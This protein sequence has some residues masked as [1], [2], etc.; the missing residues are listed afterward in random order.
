M[1]FQRMHQAVWPEFLHHTMGIP[2]EQ[3]NTSF[4]DFQFSLCDSDGCAVAIGQTIPLDWKGVP[5]NLPGNFVEIFKRAEECLR[6]NCF[7]NTLS[8][9]AAVVGPDHQR[10]GLSYAVLREMAR[11]AVRFGYNHL[12]APVRP[13]Q[14]SSFPHIPLDQY[15]EWKRADGLPFDYWLR[16]HHRL[17][18]TQLHVIPEAMAVRG[19]VKEWES[20]TR[21]T[22]PRSGNYLIPGALQPVSIDR[23]RDLGLYHDPNVWVQHSP[24]AVELDS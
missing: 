6:R 17:G 24:S 23:E 3:L 7:A 11:L 19:T 16:V 5:E 21:L 13:T 9:V 8:A 22:F 12:I 10:K 15:A 18:G 20:W 1:Q 2:F 14:K 4:T